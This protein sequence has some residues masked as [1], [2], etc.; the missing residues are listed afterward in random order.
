MVMVSFLPVPLSLAL[1]VRIE[2][3][4]ISKVT[5]IY[6]TPFG[7]GGIPL[8]S[9]LPR[10]WLSLVRALSPSKTVMVTVVC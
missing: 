2:F 3:S 9:N 6:G 5:S 10:L 1:T 8:I 4:S 7:A